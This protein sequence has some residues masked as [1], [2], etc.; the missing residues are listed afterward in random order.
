MT[1]AAAVAKV[2]YSAIVLDATGT[3]ADASSSF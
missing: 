2:Q 3:W 1:M